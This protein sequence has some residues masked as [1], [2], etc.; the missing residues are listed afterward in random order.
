MVM[1]HLIDGQILDSDE[2]KAIDQR[3]SLLVTEV[4]APIGNAFMNPCH[5]CAALGALWRA[6]HCSVK[7]SLGALQV[8]LVMAEE[9]RTAGLLSCAEGRE[10][11]QADITPSVC[12]AGCEWEC[13]RV[14]RHRGIPVAGR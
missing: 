7:L 5:D 14:T 13:G 8:L 9:L 4:A 11:R 10:A 12:R 1:H 6:F 3:A 2:P